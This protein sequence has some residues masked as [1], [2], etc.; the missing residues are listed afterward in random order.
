MHRGK[1]SI[2]SFRTTISLPD[3]QPQSQDQH[4]LANMTIPS[5][6][7]DPAMSNFVGKY[8]PV[9]NRPGQLLNNLVGTVT[10][11]I[12]FDQVAGRVDYL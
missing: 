5:Q 11:P 7:F 12:T 3:V 10:N 4:S 6:C 2:S 9:P 1:Q 8:V